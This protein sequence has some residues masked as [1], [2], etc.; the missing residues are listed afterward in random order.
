MLNTTNFINRLNL[1]DSLLRALTFTFIVGFIIRLIPEVLA[2]STPIGFDTIHYAVMMK[3]G[4]VW[5][6][7]SSFFTSTWLLYALTVPLYTISQVDPFL[8]LKIV[9]PLLYGLN[10]AG[11][12]YFAKKTLEWSSVKSLVAS[13]FFALQLASLRIS[14]D[15]LR[16]TLG[17][18]VLLL[19]LPFMYKLNTKWG[20]TSFMALS[21]LT[22]FAHEYAAVTLLTIVIGLTLA[23]VI[24]RKE[25]EIIL[26]SIVAVTPALAVFL[27]NIYLRINPIQYFV[28]TNI[29]F[30][31]I[32][33]VNPG[34]LFFLVNYLNVKDSVQYYPTYGNLVVG[35]G[36]LFCLLYL[37]YLFLVWKGSFKSSILNVW[38]GLLL[39]GSFSCLL[40]PFF[41][42]DL[43]N[44]WMFMLVYP[45][46][47]YAVHGLSKILNTNFQKNFPHLSIASYKVKGMI[48]LTSFLGILYLFTPVLMTS[49]NGGIG[50]LPL[51]YKYFSTSPAVPYQDV[52]S[53]INAMHSVNGNLDDG[54]CIILHHAFLGWG[55]L[56]LNSSHTVIHFQTDADLALN[57]A[58]ENGFSHMLFVWWNQDIGWYGLTV[59]E[60]YTK[61][62]DFNRISIYEYSVI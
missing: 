57:K 27:M 54:S 52:S 39:T 21:L 22:V 55:Q 42:V 11:I 18:A 47:F 38:T 59:P 17:M 61:L 13:V 31:D 28:K 46:T 20:F 36:A 15:L 48:L 49:V 19:T 62:Q 6:H 30:G 56:C 5:H 3:N 50:S 4:V 9:A 12:Y 35:V 43:W 25:R 45:F 2:F 1:K 32:V 58:V 8:L 41:A 40:V 34:G 33:R 26:K 10:V 29:I 16:N 44:R 51:V 53:V 24:Q 23:K 37:P 7:W 60:Y 14:W